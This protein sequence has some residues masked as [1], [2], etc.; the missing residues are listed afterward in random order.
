MP[1]DG[2]K[3]GEDCA[4]VMPGVTLDN[5]IAHE[6]GHVLNLAN[7]RCADHIMGPDWPAVGPTGEECGWVD[8]AWCGAEE[9]PADPPPPP[10]PTTCDP[11]HDCVEGEREPLILDLNGDGIHTTSPESA[12]VWF[13]LDGDG[14][15]DITGWTHPAT[16]EGILYYDRNRNGIIDGGGELYGDATPTA[17][18]SVAS[19]G[20]D[21]RCPR[22]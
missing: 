11:G 5:L 1:R 7:S 6:L 3:N 21:A 22:P 2:D 4:W 20:I 14:T 12:P 17:G 8:E 13:D 10:I 18:G 16:G 15:T 19:S 9:V